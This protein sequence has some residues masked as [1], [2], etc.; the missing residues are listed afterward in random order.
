MLV[1]TTKGKQTMIDKD[2]IKAAL[3]DHNYYGDEFRD[4]CNHDWEGLDV[5]DF[6]LA[7]DGTFD[8]EFSFDNPELGGNIYQLNLDV[9]GYLF[10]YL[11]SVHELA[12][13]K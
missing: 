12:N 5:R 11:R 8:I 4:I 7:D 10:Q 1:A 6:S 3:R 13:L 9:L 2:L